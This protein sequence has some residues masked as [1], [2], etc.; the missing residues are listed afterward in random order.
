REGLRAGVGPA[1]RDRA[2]AAAL[3]EAVGIAV[4]A[5][6]REG[7]VPRGENRAGVARE[8]ARRAR[9]GGGRRA[10]G[11]EGAVGIDGADE[12]ILAGLDSDDSAAMGDD[13]VERGGEGGILVVMRDDP[14]RAAPRS[15]A[16]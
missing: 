16:D 14:E 1:D 8:T 4:H 7:F 6:H 5:D 12:A 11:A 13:R 15:V 3:A 9:A 10:V 2:G